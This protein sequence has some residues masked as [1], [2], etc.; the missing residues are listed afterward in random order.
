MDATAA[1]L[2]QA[3]VAA[4]RPYLEKVAAVHEIGPAVADGESWLATAL[5]ELLS[6]PFVRQRRGPLEVF[7][8]SL[9]FPTSA[10]RNAGVAPASRAQAEIAALPGDIYG[11]AP[12]SSQDLGE[13]VW[14]AHLEWGATKAAVLTTVCWFG[15]DL[16]DRSKIEAAAAGV[17]RR[18][19]VAPPDVAQ[20]GK[21]IIDL[22]YPG[23]GEALE[24]AT[25]VEVPIVA[26]GPH[27]DT[28]SLE[29]AAAR[30]AVAL[31]RSRFFADPGLHLA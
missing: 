10:L 22:E 17:G 2:H 23:S 14:R 5:E 8:E 16:A 9:R 19:L 3:L 11:L 30:G 29:A 13:A 7:Q 6:L 31:P 27:V 15:R 28:A 20:C 12:A 1:D 18:L 26:Y 25:A 4:Y 24:L 21:V